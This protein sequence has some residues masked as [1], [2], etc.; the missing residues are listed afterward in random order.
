MTC[1]SGLLYEKQQGIAVAVKPDIDDFL[2]MSRFFSLVPEPVSGSAPVNGLAALHGFF[3]R[4]TVYPCQH[5]NFQGGGVLGNDGNQSLIV[6]LNGIEPV[7]GIHKRT[8]MF[9]SD[10]N[11]LACCTVYSP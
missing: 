1:Q 11:C 3:K 5:Q 6:P 8:G 9:C 4:S 2:G 10:M 7:S